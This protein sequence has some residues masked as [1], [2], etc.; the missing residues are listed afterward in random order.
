MFGELNGNSFQ[1]DIPPITACAPPKTTPTWIDAT[2]T[3]PGGYGIFGNISFETSCALADD[4]CYATCTNAAIACGSQ[5]QAWKDRNPTTIETELAISTGVGTSTVTTYASF[6]PSAFEGQTYEYAIGTGG[7]QVVTNVLY[8]Y[9]LE[10]SRRYTNAPPTCTPSNWVQCTKGSDAQRCAMQY[11]GHQ[12]CTVQGGTVRLFWWPSL[13]TSSKDVTGGPIGTRN[14]TGAFRS[15]SLATPPHTTAPFAML[16]N[17]TLTWPSVY[18]SFET[19][20]ATN[21]CGQTVGQ[22]FPGALLPVDP[23]SLYTMQGALDF[24]VAT[25]SG[26]LSTFYPSARFNFDDVTGLVPVSVYIAQPSCIAYGCYTVYP[27]YAPVLVL[28][29][30]V[31]DFDPAWKSC[32]LDWR[33]AWDPPVALTSQAVVAS[34]TMPGVVVS[35][36]AA[37]PQSGVSAPAQQTQGVGM[38]SSS[39]VVTDSGVASSPVSQPPVSAAASPSDNSAAA[40]SLALAL[41]GMLQ[42]VAE[43]DPVASTATLTSPS[44]AVVL[45]L[46]TAALSDV[47]PTASPDDPAFESGLDSPA[48][49]PSPTDAYQVFS[50]ARQSAA[51][52]AAS[53]ADPGASADAASSQYAAP[54]AFSD[55]PAGS[56]NSPSISVDPTT[57]TDP[58]ATASGDQKISLDATVYPT[59]PD[60]APWSDPQDPTTVIPL[61][62][63]S[64]YPAVAVFT[65]ASETLTAISIPPTNGNGQPGLAISVASQTIVINSDP[66][67]LSGHTLSAATNGIIVDGTLLPFSAPTPLSGL[68]AS[69]ATLAMT[70]GGTAVITASLLPQS[71]VQIGA[72]T[73]R[74][75]SSALVIAGHTLSAVPSG[76]VEDG[77][78]TLLFPSIPTQPSSSTA[79]LPADPVD[80][81]M[82]RV[83]STETSTDLWPVLA[84]QSL[85]PSGPALV[86]SGHTFTAVSNGLLEDGTLLGYTPTTASSTPKTFIPTRTTFADATGT[87]TTTTVESSAFF[88]PAVVFGSSIVPISDGTSD[89]E[90]SATPLLTTFPPRTGTEKASPPSPTSTSSAAP[91]WSRSGFLSMAILGWWAGVCVCASWVLGV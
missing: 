47:G 10:S 64:S 24:F 57:S 46:S 53:P 62:S 88:L 76:I 48:S 69:V 38:P 17:R 72:Q 86:L 7:L 66:T 75:G 2:A 78:T 73:L 80:P 71:E 52:L 42:S 49:L 90:S 51:S 61:S 6:S 58:A 40:L 68:P 70:L 5:W 31:R 27:N 22:T 1:V 84:S 3:L 74:P 83:S 35:T 89:S 91:V 82:A 77:S 59:Q 34:V 67:V 81:I 79:L 21:D 28:P 37:A 16:G 33:G 50:Q 26:Q 56:T 29:Q 44:A 13:S 54:S 36:S 9:T 23:S 87:D 12:R 4:D 39:V 11:A 60:P 8:D 43:A 32:E 45:P 30:Q 63:S 25:S 19:A 18:I 65:L 41:P 85:T 15:T 14:G 55:G 20:Y